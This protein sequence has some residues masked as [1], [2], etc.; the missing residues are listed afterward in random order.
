MV[1]NSGKGGVG[2]FYKVGLRLVESRASE[3][4]IAEIN[5]GLFIT[6]IL[7]YHLL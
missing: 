3:A 1:H 2:I 5:A 4:M 7:I 6:T